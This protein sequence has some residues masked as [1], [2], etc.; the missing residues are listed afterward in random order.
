MS[1]QPG[2]SIEHEFHRLIL[3][4]ALPFM[5]LIGLLAYLGYQDALGDGALAVV[6]AAL[7]LLL[8]VLLALRAARRLTRPL[9]LIASAACA[10]GAHDDTLVPLTGPSELQAM[11]RELNRM[12]EARRDFEV[13]LREND[14]R[15]RTVVESNRDG[16]LVVNA[17]GRLREVND[18]YLRRSG[19][20]R[21]ELL[22]MRVTDVEARETPA[23]LYAHVRAIVAKGGE[24]FE[25][26][27]RAKDGSL[28][29]VEVAV[30]PRVDRSGEMLT[31]VRDISERKRADAILRTRM[32]LA[33]LGQAG[34]IDV[35]LQAALDAAEE[36]SGSQIG[37]FH[38]VDPDQEHL[39]LQAWSTN[40]LAHM[41]TAEGRGRHCAIS[42]AGVWVDCFRTRAPVIHNDY[43]GLAH[44]KGLPE[45]HSP[46]KRVL[47]VP[48][49]RDGKVTQIL[50]VGNKAVDYVHSDV[51]VV[52]AIAGMVQDLVERIRAED[53]LKVSE[54][55]ERALLAALP[56]G[57]L[58]HRNGR[59]EYANEVML[60]MLGLGRAQAIVDHHLHEFVP[61]AFQAELAPAFAPPVSGEPTP[62]REV[63]VIR[64][65]GSP[66]EVEMSGASL[67]TGDTLRILVMRDVSARKAANAKIQRLTNFLAA[68]SQCNQA[69]LHCSGEND[70][71]QQI[72]S[73]IVNYGGVKLA[74]IGLVN[75]AT[76]MLTVAA[77]YGDDTGHL[78][79]IQVS[80][81]ASKPEGRGPGGTAV[82]ENRPVW[83]QDFLRE[84]GTRSRHDRARKAGWLSVAAVPLSRGGEVMGALSLYASEI[85]AF[86]QEVQHLVV[87]MAENINFAL[88]HLAHEA[89]RAQIERAL[90]ESEGRLSAIFQA[91]P[92]GIIVTGVPDGTILEVN[93]AALR[94]FGRERVATI[95]RTV[96][97]LGIY[98]DPKQREEMTQLLLACGSLDRFP[99]AVYMR[100][101]AAGL[102]ELSG[103]VIE[104]QGRQCLV[105]MMLDISERR[106]LEE[107]HLQAQKLESLGTLAGGIAHDFNN[108]LAAI[109]GNADLAAQDVG[110]GHAAAQSLDE[111]RV[112]SMRAHDLVRRI[113][114]FGRPKESQHEVVALDVVVVEVLKLLRSVLRAGISLDT[115]FAPETPHVLADAGQLHEAVV[116]LTTNAAYAIGKRAGTIEYRLEPV[117]VEAAQA[118]GIPGL[119]AGRYARL[120]VSD[121]GCGMDTTTL[122]RI[123]DVFYT[124]K[125]VGEGAG[126]GLSMVHG[127]MR[128]HG[129]AVTVQSTPSK[130]S[131]FALYF[132]A[133]QVQA[134]KAGRSAAVQ[135]VPASGKRVLY[136]D[137]EASLVLLASRVLARLGHKVSTFTEPQQALAALRAQPRDF[138]VLVTDLSMPHMS[139]FEL[140]TEALALSPDLP[141]LMTTGY[142]T[143]EDEISARALGIREIVLKPVTMD[144]LGRILDRL[145]REVP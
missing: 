13:A 48:I 24:T 89:E 38:F 142:I 54:E 77:S 131:R 43:A 68:L 73:A 88:D 49:L 4:S 83:C 121:D 84:P 143:V 104:L 9:A 58:T 7:A 126:L 11:A 70:L 21:E 64:A 12:I 78:Q 29:P 105:A 10:R 50:G 118:R 45:G 2:S 86:D 124:T 20:T 23:Q 127:I 106:R 96:L 63:Q 47:V 137:D 62:P 93:D 5:V 145:L 44:R 135:D 61:G 103:R 36:I 53:A 81:D 75:Q 91:S 31:F 27:H 123:F 102:V 98:A 32:R 134:V 22:G 74:W 18:A 112:A 85:G 33:E 110:P 132:P 56:D 82:R 94:L 111:I 107:A 26:L 46:V 14:A 133:A 76:G 92:L 15:Y 79:G 34:D 72:C 100:D 8:S 30:I 40:T 55:Q 65:D 66:L 138:D 141:V 67:K 140:A 99:V 6:L 41:C 52:Q 17:K 59:I 129:G 51:E 87:E 28:W 108:I 39:N 37:F 130:G 116:N 119:K 125:P 117:Q 120:T 90:K 101:A 113:M 139:G 60:R 35:L 42:E 95:G 71:F 1:K 57:V 19:Y 16:F 3:L 69:V 80:T 115:A 97:E 122:A 144:E 114:A 136:V 25:T 128:S 109:R